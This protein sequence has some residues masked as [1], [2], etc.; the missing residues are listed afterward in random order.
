MIIPNG[1]S[2]SLCLKLD[3]TVPAGTQLNHFI[4]Y[5]V[6]NDGSSIIL[7]V[8]KII[9]GETFTG[10]IQPEYVNSD[11][12]NNYNEIIKNLTEKGLIS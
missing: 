6:V 2:G 8:N 9:P 12:S 10:I 7:D 5:R 3:G 11:I 4:L 1:P